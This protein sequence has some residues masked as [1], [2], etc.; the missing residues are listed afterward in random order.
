MSAACAC[1]LGYKK[2]PPYALHNV[3]SRPAPAKYLDHN[4]DNQAL[5]YGEPLKEKP[6][7]VC[8]RRSDRRLKLNSTSSSDYECLQVTRNLVYS[9]S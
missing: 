2:R 4:R 1:P 8:Y 7:V 6:S 3:Q 9:N 5:V